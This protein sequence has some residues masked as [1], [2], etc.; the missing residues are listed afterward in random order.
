[1][2]STINCRK[3]GSLFDVSHM[4]GLSLKGKDAISFLEKLVVGD[5]AGLKDNSGTLSVITNE[6]GGIIDD[7]VVTKVREHISRPCCWEA[8]AQLRRHKEFRRLAEGPLAALPAPQA[9]HVA[10]CQAECSAE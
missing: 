9:H 3:N 1:M 2:D 7:T 5:I 4:C 6:K 8:G 10:V